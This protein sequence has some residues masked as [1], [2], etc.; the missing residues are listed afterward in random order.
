M[1]KTSE[2]TGRLTTSLEQSIGVPVRPP[3]PAGCGAGWSYVPGHFA[4]GGGCGPA[5]LV[6]DRLVATA[7]QGT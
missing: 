4:G 5:S 2:V 7:E 3:V 6:G 1:E